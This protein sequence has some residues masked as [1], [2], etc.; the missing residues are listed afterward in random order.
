MRIS[1]QAARVQGYLNAGWLLLLQQLH[2]TDAW[3]GQLP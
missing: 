2:L 1:E 3:L